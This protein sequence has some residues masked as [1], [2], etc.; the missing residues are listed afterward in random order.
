[1]IYGCLQNNGDCNVCENGYYGYQC[2]ESCPEFCRLDDRVT[3]GC[4]KNKSG[5][6]NFCKTGY[7][8]KKC[9][10]TCPGNC[11]GGCEKSGECSCKAGFYGSKCDKNCSLN[12]ATAQCQKADGHCKC[13]PGYKAGTCA[14]SK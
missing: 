8:G 2:I 6:C 1:M 14:N 12:C 13:K 4:P 9:R 3:F 5:D 11:D 10:D 7:H